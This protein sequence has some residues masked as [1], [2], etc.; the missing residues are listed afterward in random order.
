VHTLD[1]FVSEEWFICDQAVAVA[2]AVAAAAAAAA[3]VL[4]VL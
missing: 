4:F 1:H 2:V 3:A